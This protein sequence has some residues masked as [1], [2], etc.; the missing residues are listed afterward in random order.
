MIWH[1]PKKSDFQTPKNLSKKAIRKRKKTCDP[2]KERHWRGGPNDQSLASRPWNALAMLYKLRAELALGKNT[3]SLEDP[4][5]HLKKLFSD[6]VVS[7]TWLSFLMKS[8]YKCTFLWF[9]VPLLDGCVKPIHP[10]I[11]RAGV[12]ILGN[13][14]HQSIL[15]SYRL[16]NPSVSSNSPVAK[17]VTHSLSWRACGFK[18]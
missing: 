11:H 15:L 1:F 16:V 18:I 8:L 4:Q 9:W 3:C 5:N 7:K 12:P 2:P 13:W 10:S 6:N 17:K 14:Q